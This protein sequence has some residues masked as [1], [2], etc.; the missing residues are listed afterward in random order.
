LAADAQASQFL[1][2]PA[3]VIEPYVYQCRECTEWVISSQPAAFQS[4]S[5]LS[6]LALASVLPSGLDFSEAPGCV[7]RLPDT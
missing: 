7:S 1:E 6:M 2:Q 5:V 3:T 4:R